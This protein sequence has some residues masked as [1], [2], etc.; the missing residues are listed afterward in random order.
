VGVVEKGF[1]CHR[2]C[3]RI[4]RNKTGVGNN[5]SKF[6][7]F[8]KSQHESLDSLN[9]EVKP[10]PSRR[11]PPA[12]ADLKFKR[13]PCL[14]NKDAEVQTALFRKESS[15]QKGSDMTKLSTNLFFHVSHT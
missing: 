12:A 9:E 15:T 14:G 4:S 2:R 13:V 5:S 10:C 3:V 1:Q 11:Q 8:L 7:V 6:L